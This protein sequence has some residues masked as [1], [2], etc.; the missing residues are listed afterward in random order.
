MPSVGSV[1]LHVSLTLIPFNIS[2]SATT[3]A[4][5]ILYTYKHPYL[6]TLSY[7]PCSAFRLYKVQRVVFMSLRR[8]RCA[9]IILAT[10]IRSFQVQ[11]H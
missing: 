10:F 3:E 6:L 11:C 7:L 2:P 1:D 5:D 8:L 4:F 9:G